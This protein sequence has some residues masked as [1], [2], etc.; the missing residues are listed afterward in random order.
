MRLVFKLLAI[1]LL[2]TTTI[3]GVRGQL[4]HNRQGTETP[5]PS[6]PDTIDVGPGG[7]DPD[8]YDDD[9]VE[10]DSGCK[11][12][13]SGQRCY[14]Q[15]PNGVTY[16][17]C[18]HGSGARPEYIYCHVYFKKPSKWKRAQCQEGTVCV[19]IDNTNDY[20]VCGYVS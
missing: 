15:H 4:L 6:D 10:T 9:P 16:G 11:A 18:C 8:P 20:L 3:V 17:R 12:Q 2:I 7:F 13:G 1:L 19:Q 5:D 14:P